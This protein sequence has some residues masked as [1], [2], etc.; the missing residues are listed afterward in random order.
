MTKPTRSIITAI[1]AAAVALVAGATI[2]CFQAGSANGQADVSSRA[3]AQV[4]EHRLL[5]RPVTVEG[6]S[7]MTGP[8]DV[9]VG[10]HEFDPDSIYAGCVDSQLEVG[11]S[12]WLNV[13]TIR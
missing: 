4:E 3:A 12:S 7:P 10:A 13:C 2:V 6:Y 8:V 1:I 9:W 5:N 11:G